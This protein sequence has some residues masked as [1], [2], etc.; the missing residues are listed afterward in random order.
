VTLIASEGFDKINAP[1]GGPDGKIYLG[2]NG[3]YLG[4]IQNP[5]EQ[6]Q[7]CNY[8]PEAVYLNSGTSYR[9]LPQTLPGIYGSTGETLTV[10]FEME[11]NCFGDVQNFTIST[12]IPPDSVLWN[13]GDP[14][15]GINNTSRDSKPSHRF[16]YPGLF[17][18]EL[19]YYSLEKITTVKKT[20]QVLNCTPGLYEIKIP[21]VF[22]PNQDNINDFWVIRNIEYYP[23][24][25][26]YVYTRWGT[27]VFRSRGYQYPWDGIFDGKLLSNGTYYYVIIL[28]NGTPALTGHVSIYR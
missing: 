27:L 4:A 20:V 25:E 1:Q 16:S 7:L 6:G 14:Q 13:F 5:D 19:K 10:E 26:V 15:S 9:G 8:D 17:T 3:H 11:N 28:N 24:A 2:T 22:T 12:S 23:N 21:N 18:I